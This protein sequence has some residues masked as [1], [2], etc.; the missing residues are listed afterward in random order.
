MI[1]AREVDRLVTLAK[2]YD[3]KPRKRKPAE[4]NGGQA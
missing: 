3:P 1:P 4:E 2:P